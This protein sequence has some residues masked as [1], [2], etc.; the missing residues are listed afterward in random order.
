MNGAIDF[1]TIVILSNAPPNP[2]E[3]V[4]HYSE[5]LRSLVIVIR[6]ILGKTHDSDPVLEG[7]SLD[8]MT[9]DCQQLQDAFLVLEQ[10]RTLPLDETRSATVV[11]A[12]VYHDLRDAIRQ[13]GQTLGLSISYWQSHDKESDASYQRILDHLFDQ[14]CYERETGIYSAAVYPARSRQA[15]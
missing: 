7:A 10:F 13:L 6:A 12:E 9:K 1:W 3:F 11:I 14:L 2:R 4:L 8:R 5:I 15:K